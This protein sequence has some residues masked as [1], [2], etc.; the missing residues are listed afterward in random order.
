MQK[1]AKIGEGGGVERLRG[2]LTVWRVRAIGAISPLWVCLDRKE[3]RSSLCPRMDFR[4]FDCCLLFRAMLGGKGW[5]SSI[6]NMDGK[7]RDCFNVAGSQSGP[8]V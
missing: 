1:G 2:G 5:G 7:A 8:A 3:W 6:A 4:Q